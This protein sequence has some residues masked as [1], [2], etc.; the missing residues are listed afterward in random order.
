MVLPSASVCFVSV[1]AMAVYGA[2][3]TTLPGCTSA[4][5]S[6]SMRGPIGPSGPPGA[7]GGGGPGGG[8]CA[9]TA[10]APQSS[11]AANTAWIN[12]LFIRISP[13][14]SLVSI[15]QRFRCANL[16]R[17]FRQPHRLRQ[18]IVTNQ[19]IHLDQI[20]RVLLVHRKTQSSQRAALHL[21]TD[22]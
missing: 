10:E 17:R 22:D 18:S 5:P 1:T 11:A 20:R 12:F 8:S 16:F 6:S 3:V 4:K 14:L 7:S 9:R 2:P 13:L 21:H 19:Q 15:W